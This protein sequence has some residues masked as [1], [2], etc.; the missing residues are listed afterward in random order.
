V[1]AATGT[2]VSGVGVEIPPD[3][4]TTAEV[5]ERGDLGRFGFAAGWLERV[6]GVRERRWTDPS[7]TPYRGSVQTG[8]VVKLER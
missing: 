5:E 1:T 8:A 6:T 4:V 3:L 2:C 7:I